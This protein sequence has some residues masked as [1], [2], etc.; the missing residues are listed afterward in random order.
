MVDLRRSLLRVSQDLDIPAAYREHSGSPQLLSVLISH[1]IHRIGMGQLLLRFLTEQNL[2]GKGIQGFSDSF[3]RHMSLARLRQGSV[4]EYLERIRLGILRPH[5]FRG[6]F[7]AHGMRAGWPLTDFIDLAYRLHSAFSSAS[8]AASS[9]A[10]RAALFSF[11]FSK[12]FLRRSNT[13]GTISITL[14]TVS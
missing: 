3:I 7:R 5:P 14:V 13:S 10:S 2:D 4:Q 9:T 1:Q 8:R 11:S 6:P 12:P